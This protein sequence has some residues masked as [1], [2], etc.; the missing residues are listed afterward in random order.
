MPL[1]SPKGNIP[2]RVR[3]INA[4]Q[5]SSITR[6]GPPL[7]PGIGLIAMAQEA[8]VPGNSP[9]EITLITP[10]QASGIPGTNLQRLATLRRSRPPATQ[11]KGPPKVCLTAPAQDS[12]LPG[13][14]PPDFASSPLSR[15]L[16]SPGTPPTAILFRWQKQLTRIFTDWRDAVTVET[17][18][19]VGVCSQWK[20]L[21]SEI[22]TSFDLLM[23]VIMEVSAAMKRRLSLTS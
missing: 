19:L 14:S 3:L 13:R 9:L 18:R 1:A 5:A 22:Y 4:V 10:A 2:Q 7:H 8:G 21:G 16:V 12:G 15:L 17:S 23:L 6:N 11:G 20:S